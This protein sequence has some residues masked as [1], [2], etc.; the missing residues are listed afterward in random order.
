LIASTKELHRDLLVLS[1]ST[2]D[3]F[4]AK[5]KLEKIAKDNQTCELQVIGAQSVRWRIELVP[6]FF[7][8]AA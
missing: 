6:E 2:I 3:F 4:G 1:E 7:R 5:S 8:A